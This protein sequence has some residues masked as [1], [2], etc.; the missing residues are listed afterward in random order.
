MQIA[1]EMSVNDVPENIWVELILSDYGFEIFC[2]NK[3]PRVKAAYEYIKGKI[4]MRVASLNSDLVD[5]ADDFKEILA[6][7]NK[8]GSSNEHN[9]WRKV[10]IDH[11]KQLRCRNCN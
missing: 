9:R 5:G 4:P 7:L 10:V 11:S 1:I 3:T 8:N 2:P 6:N